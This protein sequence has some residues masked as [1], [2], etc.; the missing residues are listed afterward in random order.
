MI[1]VMNLFLKLFHHQTF[2]VP[3]NQQ[4]Y[5]KNSKKREYASFRLL[6]QASVNVTQNAKR[7]PLKAIF[8]TFH[9]R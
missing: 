4:S 5:A 7:L 6:D 3:E 9:P 8:V 2:R 1:S